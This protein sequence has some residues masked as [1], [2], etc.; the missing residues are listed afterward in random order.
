MT[1]AEE[2]RINEVRQNLIQ[3]M[4]SPRMTSERAVELYCFIHKKW[5]YLK[6]DENGHNPVA[7]IQERHDS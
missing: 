2:I 1:N 5:G 4:A 7:I 6:Y 3:Y